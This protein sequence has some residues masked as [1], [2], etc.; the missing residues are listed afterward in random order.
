MSIMSQKCWGGG[1]EIKPKYI[2][3]TLSDLKEEVYSSKLMIRDFNSR[4]T[5]QNIN[6]KIE[7]LNTTINQ[8][9]STK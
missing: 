9:D 4:V 1:R 5:R 3:K 6:N 8:L 2:K 7:E